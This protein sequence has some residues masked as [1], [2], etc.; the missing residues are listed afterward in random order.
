MNE[1]QNRKKRIRR[2]MAAVLLSLCLILTL[3]PVEYY[4]FSISQTNDVTVTTQQEILSFSELSSDVTNQN[5]G[6]GTPFTSLQLPNQLTA[7]C[8]SLKEEASAN[9]EMTET[10]DSE[11]S[12]T[13]NSENTET[14]DSGT[15]ETTDSE[16]TETPDSEI[17]ETP[18]P[19][20]PE[21]PN[22]ETTDTPDTETI[23][24]QDSKP[25]K[26]D[27]PEAPTETTTV[28]PIETDTPN[29]TT[30]NNTSDEHISAETTTVTIKNNYASPDEL[31]EFKEVSLQEPSFTVETGVIEGITWKSSPEYDS[32]TE[33]TYQFTPLLPAGYVLAEGV[34]APQ[35]T[36]TISE[37]EL[38]LLDEAS[39]TET[40]P[41][42]IPEFGTI[43][44]SAVWEAGVLENGELIIES[45]VTLT[46]TGRLEIKGTV[47]ISGGG[48]IVRGSD[49]A[50]LLANSSEL[51]ISGITLDGCQVP[52]DYSMIE[53]NSGN[54]I[55]NDGCKIMNCIKNTQRAA[56]VTSGAALYLE[57]GTAVFNQ[58]EITNC[59]SNYRGGAAHIKNSTVTIHNG[60]Y[61]N[62]R[63]TENNPQGGGFIYNE[64]STLTINGGNFL[65][66][67]SSGKGGCIYHGSAG[68]TKTK[69]YGGYFHGNKSSYPGYEGSGAI[70]NSAVD[71]S[72]TELTLSGSVQF[73][74]DG[75]PSSGTDGIYLD[76]QSE[77][78]RK[79][80]M[81]GT[82]VYPVKIYLNA[83]EGYAIAEGDGYTLLEERDMKKITFIDTGNSNKEWYAVLDPE[84]NQV[85][86]SEVKPDYKLYITYISNGAQG[87]IRD[88]NGYDVGDDATIKSA[89][90]LSLKDCFFVGWNTSADGSGAF[91]YPEQTIQITNDLDL[92]AYFVNDLTGTFYSG[93]ANQSETIKTTPADRTL[94]TPELKPLDGFTAVGWSESPDSYTGNIAEN[95]EL[96]LLKDTSYYG[97]YKK[98]VT[99]S[100][101]LQ[102][103]ISNP[104]DTSKPLYANVHD[105]ITYELPQFILNSTAERP[106]YTL[107]GWTTEAD[108]SGELFLPNS[109][110]TFE[111]DT[112]LYANWKADGH[113]PYIVEH[114]LQNATADAYT[115]IDSDTQHL[116][117]ETGTLV[118]AEVKTYTGFTE[119]TSH[120]SRKAS[121]TVNEDGSL[122]LKLYYDRDI[123]EISFDLNGNNDTAPQT[124][125]I[126]YGNPVSQ[127]SAPTHTGYHF[128]GWYTDKECSAENQWAFEKNVEDNTDSHSVTL[129]AKWVDDIA[130]VLGDVSFNEGYKNFW[131][132][133]IRKKS[134]I[135]TV[136]ITEEGSGLKQADYVLH[137]EEKTDKTRASSEKTAEIETDENGLTLA[138]IVIDTDFKGTVTLTGT[139]NAGNISPEK[140]V[141]AENGKIIVEDNAPEIRFSSESGILPEFFID[142]AKVNVIVE[143]E[144]TSVENNKISGGLSQ[145]VYQIDDGEEINASEKSFEDSIVTTCLFD[146]I[147]PQ[148][149][150]HTLHVTALDNAGN[151]NTQQITVDIKK[152][153]Q[154]YKIEHYKQNLDGTTYTKEDSDTKEHTETVGTTVTAAPNTY[155]G[156][157][158]NTSISSRVPSGIVDETG[159]LVLKLYY[160]RE[161]YNIQYDLNGGDG[162]APQNQTARY[163]ALLH[164]APAPSKKGYAFKGWYKD[165][166]G[167]EGSKWNFEKDTVLSPV[168]LYAKWADETPPV[169]GN[170]VYHTAYK[171]I[172]S[173]IIQ[174]PSMIITVPITEE[175]SG[176]KQADYTL[177]S[178]SRSV[179][180]SKADIDTEDGQITAKIAINDDFKG[181]I[182]LSASD[183]AGN[184]SADKIITA[185]GNGVIVE[186]TAPEIRFSSKTGSLSDPFYQEAAID[187]TVTDAINNTSISSGISSISYQIDEKE[188]IKMPEKEFINDMVESY[189]F[190]IQISNE[191]TH[192][193]KVTAVDNAGNETTRQINITIDAQKET[194][195]ENIEPPKKPEKKPKKEPKEQKK[196]IIKGTNPPQPDAVQNNPSP[197]NSDEPQTG[198]S[199]NI[200]LYVT[201]AMISGFLYL[202][203]LFIA[204]KDKKQR[205]GK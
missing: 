31:P 183:N 149:G 111:N 10:P 150:T 43:S 81:S 87:T 191:G 190:M 194:I 198:D 117:A 124:Q 185:P 131:N 64:S 75:N 139:D 143:D 157:V 85:K 99:V 106:G 42:T 92:Y 65:D 202:L 118:T 156:F 89:E 192:S 165:A 193:I 181:S 163:G 177:V 125:Y 70:Y 145:I 44:T 108:G 26:D 12:E 9:T 205:N 102:G 34:A 204:K 122:I 98:D 72:S 186:D 47:T 126:L 147:I 83:V 51:T 39:S 27:N 15:S 74:G 135:I 107:L 195:T 197:Q 104:D 3:L 160:D 4:G 20:T 144:D 172:L 66:N 133:I 49:Q 123:Y 76:Y 5:V 188:E 21:T 30:Q 162:T 88:E 178:T 90:G 119:N 91:Y 55:L 167:T 35:I 141:T 13:P 142:S 96:T 24:E 80:Y 8:R 45:G 121:G 116:T 128:K 61:S 28:K 158:E 93:S 200:E 25:S 176:V 86:L 6:I 82:L 182:L 187:V 18:N 168:T 180:K 22:S 148:A 68:N 46:L 175:G 50:Q 29:E 7:V 63:T 199:S 2:W 16:I 151:T 110:Q 113:T 174:K 32:E 33:G 171:N 14:P 105:I 37:H 203:L 184:I 189:P 17:T 97:I 101:D 179:T 127:P 52:S 71:T 69:I 79:I 40:P 60:T 94:I 53:S 1:L 56:R 23:P 120:P 201:I 155:T 138:K 78:F 169:L 58:A 67:T 129:Y 48:T 154:T 19:E 73:S 115:K 152:Q 173:W 109:L 130:P 62:N 77:T 112:I 159:S 166:L 170:A 41:S 100:Y 132:Q 136:P 38:M 161:I 153:Q 140:S 196:E 103:I 84:T 54:I 137:S 146:V 164:T 59:S 95:T 57:R 134:L 11:T 114:Y 36:V